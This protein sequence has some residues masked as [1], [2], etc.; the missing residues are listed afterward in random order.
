[1]PLTAPS[2]LAVSRLYRVMGP[3]QKVQTL[4]S[5]GQQYAGLGSWNTQS[6]F[7]TTDWWP[8]SFEVFARITW[9][10]TETNPHTVEL[11]VAGRKFYLPKGATS[12]TEMRLATFIAPET[13]A[14]T[15][16]V[17]VKLVSSTETSAAANLSATV[18]G[19]ADPALTSELRQS[20]DGSAL[21]LPA[22]S[23]CMDAGNGPPRAAISLGGASVGSAE[24]GFH[25][26]QW[27][28]PTNLVAATTYRSLWTVNGSA[29]GVKTTTDPFRRSV[30][31]YYY[32]NFRGI[33]REVFFEA[34]TSSVAF[35]VVAEPLRVL[36]NQPV[37]HRLQATRAATWEV[38]SGMPAG[39]AL[40][41]DA[42]GTYLVGIFTTTGNFSV[43]LTA[44]VVG[45]SD[46]ASGTLTIAVL[47]SDVGTGQKTTITINPGWVNNG[48]AYQTGDEVRVALTSSPAPATWRA[49]GLPPGV[50]IE[51]ANGTITGRPTTEGR[52]MASIFAQAEGYDESD[53]AVV[54]FTIRAG[55][56]TS[57]PGT[58]AKGRIPWILSRWELTDLQILAR[59]RKVE[60]TLMEGSDA[61]AALRAKIGDNLNFAVFFI[62][63]AESP[64]DL[65]PDQLRLKVRPADNLDQSLVL[66]EAIAPDSEG[67]IVAPAFNT[68]SIS[69][70]STGATSKVT[71][72]GL[73][74][75]A[76]RSA[77]GDGE[78]LME[79][80]G[81]EA[82]REWTF[83]FR[84]GEAEGAFKVGEVITI[85]RAESYTAL[86]VKGRFR[87]V[88]LDTSDGAADPW[89]VLERVDPAPYYLLTTTTGNQQR[90]T[91]LTWVQDGD[92]NDPLPC[93]AEVELVKGGKTYSSQYFP[94]MLELDVVRTG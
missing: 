15:V 37:R 77:G 55:T 89:V 93:V 76:T 3:P 4:T 30:P 11:T 17:S 10:N 22:W 41:S 27:P 65:G 80:L 21:D 71:I 69:A 28:L 2:G 90:Q 5:Y 70:G 64:F 75:G 38:T 49:V 83:G 72:A 50:G 13:A 6:T 46:T 42:T 25:D 88:T 40:D 54:T 68:L 74:S 87:V 73:T 48:L 45:G 81:R 51:A 84:G 14:K 34:A 29:V 86:P 43:A 78:T 16:E 61:K 59:T 47:A 1:M 62:D 82:G 53:P 94:M 32:T 85:T 39:F 18:D 20:S 23:G 67:G 44:T 79:F 58:S 60:S 52:F 35:A 26:T 56:G 63:H 8:G 36:R 33:V 31:G 12:A 24:L 9:T 19:C 92:K 91:L 7:G 57:A 66:A